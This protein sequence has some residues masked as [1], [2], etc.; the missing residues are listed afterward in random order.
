MSQL[1]KRLLAKGAKD[2]PRAA[3]IL[4]EPLLKAMT[5]RPGGESGEGGV[6]GTTSRNYG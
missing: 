5:V 3:D 1:L 4:Q 2:R 6:P